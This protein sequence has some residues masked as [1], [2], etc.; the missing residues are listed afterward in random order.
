MDCPRV[1]VAIRASAFVEGTRAPTA[2]QGDDEA[3]HAR[4]EQMP[5]GTLEP[6]MTRREDR[7]EHACQ[8]AAEVELSLATTSMINASSKII[9]ILRPR[10][11]TATSADGHTDRSAYGRTFQQSPKRVN[12][13]A[14]QGP[15]DEAPSENVVLP[16]RKILNHEV[17]DANT[18]SFCASGTNIDENPLKRGVHA[19]VTPALA[20]DCGLLKPQDCDNRVSSL[21]NRAN[22]HPPAA[23]SEKLTLLR[24]VP[25][26]RG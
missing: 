1:A 8:R 24:A 9:R 22:I 23:V 4:H 19:D 12:W 17:Q 5:P 14:L 21:A 13:Q 11:S 18:R 20:R 7:A 16:N 10:G 26:L 3:D 2:L 25:V 15:G 6:R